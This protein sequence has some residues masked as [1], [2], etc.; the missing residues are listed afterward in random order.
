VIVQEAG[1]PSK[2]P[3]GAAACDPSTAK[4]QR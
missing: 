4:S 1:S 2:W 3:E